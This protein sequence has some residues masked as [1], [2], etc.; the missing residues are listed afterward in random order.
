[1]RSIKYWLRVRGLFLQRT[2]QHDYYD[3]SSR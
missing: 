3:E 2:A 1:V